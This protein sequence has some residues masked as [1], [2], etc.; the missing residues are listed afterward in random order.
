MSLRCAGDEMHRQRERDDFVKASGTWLPLS[1]PSAGPNAAVLNTPPPLNRLT[2]P[3]RGARQAA[4][5]IRLRADRSWSQEALAIECD[6][7]R[8]RVA[9]V[10]G[11]ARNISQDNLERLAKA[12]GLPP[13]CLN[14]P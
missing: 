4:S 7:H 6:L 2:R 14:K 12:L 13:Y 5:L 1:T 10:A 9:Q 11:P 3:P 8:T